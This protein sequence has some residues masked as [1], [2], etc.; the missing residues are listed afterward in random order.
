MGYM[1]ESLG[2]TPW[3]SAAEWNNPD[4]VNR[5]AAAHIWG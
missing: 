1:N 2:E 4:F 5:R 3:F